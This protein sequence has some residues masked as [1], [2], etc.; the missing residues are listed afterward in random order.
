[1]G[2]SA[3]RFMSTPIRR[4]SPRFCARA[5]IGHAAKPTTTPIKSR[6]LIV[7][8]GAQETTSYRLKLVLRRGRARV[9]STLTN[10]RFG[11]KADICTAPAHVRFTPESRHKG[12]RM[13]CPLTAKSGH[14]AADRRLIFFEIALNQVSNFQIVAFGSLA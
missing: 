8:P 7:A 11:S 9:R 10:V 13:E 3:A 1:C 6:R 12:A 2:S 5:A 4:I 14:C